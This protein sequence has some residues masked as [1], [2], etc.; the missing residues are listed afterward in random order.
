[1]QIVVLIVHYKRWVIAAN[2]LVHLLAQLLL[3]KSTAD[4]NLSNACWSCCTT[5]SNLLASNW[6]LLLSHFAISLLT[7]RTYNVWIANCPIWPDTMFCHVTL[8]AHRGAIRNGRR[9]LICNSCIDWLERFHICRYLWL[10]EHGDIHVVACHSS[11]TFSRYIPLWSLPHY[12]Y[13]RFLRLQ[14]RWIWGHAL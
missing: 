5:L 14:Q 6:H 8:L 11:H 2:C 1:M 7:G 3:L 13:I 4:F 9:P 12:L 10:M